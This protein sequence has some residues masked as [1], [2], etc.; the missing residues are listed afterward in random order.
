MKEVLL[1]RYRVILGFLDCRGKCYRFSRFVKI[2]CS[3][4]SPCCSK[5]NIISAKFL[6]SLAMLFIADSRSEG[7]RLMDICPSN[8]HKSRTNPKI[9]LTSNSVQ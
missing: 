9:I 5:S 8:T 1:R 4:S 3:M 6:A 7:L 2:V